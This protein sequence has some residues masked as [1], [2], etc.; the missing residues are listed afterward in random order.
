MNDNIEREASVQGADWDSVHGG[1][2]SDPVIAAPLLDTAQE[3]I[4]SSHA[5]TVVDLGG[6][7]GTLL[8]MLHDK[9]QNPKLQLVNIDASSAQIDVSRD[10]GLKCIKS[11]IDSFDRGDIDSEHILFM[12]RSVL[13]Y[14]GRQGLCATLKHI[15][16]QAEQGE[17]FI[18]QTASFARQEDADCLN[19]LYAL[20]DTGKWYPTVEHLDEC[21]AQTGWDIVDRKPAA[22]LP[23]TSPE[24]ASRY[25]VS[26]EVMTAITKQLAQHDVPADVLEIADTGFCAYLHYWIYTTVNR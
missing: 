15:G 7:T 1:Y 21:L 2:F 9:M 26:E 6:G 25:G 19:E 3:L 10:S 4:D 5:D 18:H 22:S 23:L 12:M 11:S 20:M 13:H 14:Q 17:Y 16:E 24:L 8:R